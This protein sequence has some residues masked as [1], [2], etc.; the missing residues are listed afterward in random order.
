MQSHH[1]NQKGIGWNEVR[2]PPEL[3]ITGII[4]RYIYIC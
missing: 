2:D 1:L 3:E 4:D